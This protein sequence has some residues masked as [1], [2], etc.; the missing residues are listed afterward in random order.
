MDIFNGISITEIKKQF[1]F[2]THFVLL[3]RG[4][5]TFLSGFLSQVI[6]SWQL[7]CFGQTAS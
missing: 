2:I 7:P 6:S 4:D 1:M 3:K 5:L